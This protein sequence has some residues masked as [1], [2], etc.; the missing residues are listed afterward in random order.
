MRS[1]FQ[2]PFSFSLLLLFLSFLP[3][4]L[5]FVTRAK[6]VFLVTLCILGLVAGVTRF[7]IAAE[8]GRAT[9]IEKHLGEE[10]RFGALIVEEPDERDQTAKITV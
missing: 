2:F 10:M 3:L 9:L 6:E 7:S 4:S 1:I 5:F 8:S